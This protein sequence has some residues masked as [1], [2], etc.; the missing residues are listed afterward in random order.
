LKLLYCSRDYTTHD[1]RFVRAIVAGGIDVQYLRLENDGVGYTSESLPDGAEWVAWEGGGAPLSP[2]EAVELYR[3]PFERV[4]RRIAP[5]V[6]HAGPV[7]SFGALAGLT[8]LAPTVL[9]SWGSDMLVESRRDEWNRWATEIAVQNADGVICDAQA[10]L[11]AM[12]EFNNGRVPLHVC[13][14]WGPELLPG[15]DSQVK[16]DEIRNELGWE[17][18]RVVIA[19]R[20]WHTGY[21]VPELVEAFAKAYEQ[22]PSLRMILAGDGDE[23]DRI[24]ALILQHNLGDAIARVGMVSSSRLKDLLAA[25]DIYMSLVPSD[26]T[27]ISLI[28]AMANSLACIVTRNPGNS[29]WIIDGKSGLL[30]DAGNYDGFADALARVATDDDLRAR[31]AAHAA[32]ITRERAD[33]KTNSARIV[34]LYKKVA[35]D[36]PISH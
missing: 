13:V 3:E 21:R 36:G 34:D 1:L 32:R 19:T 30:V 4:V 33:W 11:D 14:P 23:R 16:R 27:S 15:S 12:R 7:Q 2:R 25:S 5:D 18:N 28:D 17:Q 24:A 35:A 22:E 31:L 20:A 26:G 10:V 29:E 9:C 8:R 6:M